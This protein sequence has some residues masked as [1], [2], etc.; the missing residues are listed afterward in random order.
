VAGI[1][2][3]D[4]DGDGFRAVL[5]ALFAMLD[6][7]RE[8][9]PGGSGYGGWDATGAAPFPAWADFLRDIA[10]DGGGSRDAGWRE[11]LVASR[12]GIDRF[13]EAYAAMARAA[14]AM[15]DARHLIHSD[16]LNYN[17]LV[18]PGVSSAKKGPSD[19]SLRSGWQPYEAAPVA[20]A[21]VLD[22]GCGLAGDFVYDLAWFAWYWPF[23]PAWA[24]IDIV[25]EAR[26]HYDRIGL[27]VPD[28]D[29]RL[30]CYARHIGLGDLRYNAFMGRWDLAETA[31][32]RIL[33]L[34]RDTREVFHTPPR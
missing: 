10:T 8:A 31:A 17:V 4:L 14:D 9:D 29:R 20:V 21:A 24:D 15:P 16:L 3:D 2:L 1:P 30:R 28:L 7:L 32:A 34:A 26:R 12:V 23:Y 33:A 27:A 11:K 25:A 5:P 6:A 22:W 13:D 19:P 18:E